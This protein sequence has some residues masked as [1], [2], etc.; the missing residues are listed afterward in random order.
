MNGLCFEFLFTFYVFSLVKAPVFSKHGL[1]LLQIFCLVRERASVSS[2]TPTCGLHRTRRFFLFSFYR[3]S[4]SS[5]WDIP[6]RFFLRGNIPRC[7][8]LRRFRLW[9]C[10]LLLHD[11]FRCLCGRIFTVACCFAVQISASAAVSTRSSQVM[12]ANLRGR[13]LKIV[14]VCTILSFDATATEVV[15]A[16][17]TST[18]ALRSSRFIRMGRAPFWMKRHVGGAKAA[19]SASRRGCACKVHTAT[20]I[21]AAMISKH[22]QEISDT[23]NWRPSQQ[24][25][26]AHLVWQ[27]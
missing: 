10:C 27:C 18:G 25:K 3:L 26:Q 21:N 5:C 13:C 22:R 16:S 19:A 23:K 24:E 14:Q 20:R 1:Q 15:L 11:R 12:C 7:Y 9:S 4:S 17:Q 2:S 8:I 6:N